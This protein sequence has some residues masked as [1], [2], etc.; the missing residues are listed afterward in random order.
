MSVAVLNLAL[1][2]IALPSTSPCE[3]TLPNVASQQPT[4][5]CTEGGEPC[6]SFLG[7]DSLEKFHRE[8]PDCL[9]DDDSDEVSSSQRRDGGSACFLARAKYSAARHR[10]KQQHLSASLR[11]APIP[12]IYTFCTLLI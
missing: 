2:G 3:W 6:P 12:L 8:V 4:R 5:A 11:P 10:L 9:E 7:K 1:F